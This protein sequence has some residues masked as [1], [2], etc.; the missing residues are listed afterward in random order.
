MEKPERAHSGLKLDPVSCKR[1]LSEKV[2]QLIIS[3][4]LTEGLFICHAVSAIYRNYI[5]GL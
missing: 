1:T 2:E 4:L 5:N 3:S